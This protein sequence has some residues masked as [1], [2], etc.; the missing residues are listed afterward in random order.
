MLGILFLFYFLVLNVGSIESSV[1]YVD[2]IF[3][4]WNLSKD[5]KKKVFREEN[6]MISLIFEKGQISQISCQESQIKIFMMQ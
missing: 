2:P 1:L 6:V 4:L 3:F 5:S